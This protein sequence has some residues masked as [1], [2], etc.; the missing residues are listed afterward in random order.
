MVNTMVSSALRSPDSWV[1]LHSPPE[2]I[3][4]GVWQGTNVRRN[5]GMCIF[6]KANTLYF[7]QE[8]CSEAFHLSDAIVFLLASSAFLFLSMHT[9]LLTLLLP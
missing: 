6:Q 8:L 9:T 3:M 7:S 1:Q 2:G 4:R 5:K